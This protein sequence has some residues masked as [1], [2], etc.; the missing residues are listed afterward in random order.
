MN[1]EK[2]E[3][4]HRHINDRPDSVEIGTPAK[5][6]AI[7]VYYNADDDVKTTERRIKAAFA[8]RTLAQEYHEDGK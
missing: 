7:K 1:E 8:A 6:G 5:G 3:T 4:I 2:H